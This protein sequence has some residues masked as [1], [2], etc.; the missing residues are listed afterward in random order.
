MQNKFLLC[1]DCVHLS[2]AQNFV[3]FATNNGHHRLVT[4]FKVIISSWFENHK[5]HKYSVCGQN[6]EI[7]K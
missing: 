1:E 2:Y 6:E 5:K 3:I 7:S 4:L